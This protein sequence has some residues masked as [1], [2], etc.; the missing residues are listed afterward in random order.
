MALWGEG[1]GL[2]YRGVALWALMK[3]GEAPGPISLAVNKLEK[4]YSFIFVKIKLSIKICF[5]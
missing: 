3:K 1:G 5:T 2:A 4:M